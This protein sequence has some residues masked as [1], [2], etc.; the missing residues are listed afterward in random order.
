MGRDNVRFLPWC[1]NVILCK[2][3]GGG[4]MIECIYSVLILD[5][6]FTGIGNIFFST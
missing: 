5:H 4:S 6:P 1:E 3:G 2:E